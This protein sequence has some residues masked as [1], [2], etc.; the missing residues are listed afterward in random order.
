MK[1]DIL[2]FAKKEF[3]EKIISHRAKFYFPSMFVCLLFFF[4]Y[5]L[6]LLVS[7]ALI[8]IL[9]WKVA[10]KIS[11]HHSHGTLWNVLAFPEPPVQIPRPL[12]L[13]ITA[14]LWGSLCFF[15]AW[16]GFLTLHHCVTQGWTCCFFSHYVQR[17]G[18][19]FIDQM[20]KI[21]KF[22][23]FFRA[24]PRAFLLLWLLDH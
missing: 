8:V 24:G 21:F 17:I 15:C 10:I 16:N 9:K 14:S 3:P 5:D 20:N 19:T 12:S 1:P 23:T 13:S 18:I 6:F 11:F 2:K 7:S 4:V 22:L